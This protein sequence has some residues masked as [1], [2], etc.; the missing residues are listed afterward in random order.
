MS[1]KKSP[2]AGCLRLVSPE[3]TPPRLHWAGRNVRRRGEGES[4]DLTGAA[5]PAR[6]LCTLPCGPRQPDVALG[7]ASCHVTAV[8][9]R[10]GRQAVSAPL[11]CVR[12][13]VCAPS[14]G[15]VLGAGLGHLA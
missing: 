5:G 9:E 6:L 11:R 7:C 12:G 2:W 3:G 13:P 4:G 8:T 10:A 15:M 1:A 14:G